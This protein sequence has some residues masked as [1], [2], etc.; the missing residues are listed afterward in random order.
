MDN[1]EPGIVEYFINLVVALLLALSAWVMTK[2]L[3]C[4]GAVFVY[5]LLG[6]GLSW[7]LTTLGVITLTWWQV[8]L[9]LIV[10]PYVIKFL[11]K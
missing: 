6:L 9:G 8:A 10:L 7:L 1:N 3:G 5:A 2:G 11:R 4:I